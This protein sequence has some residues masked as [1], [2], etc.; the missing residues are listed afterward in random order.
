MKRS[1]WGEP[2]MWSDR[3][4]MG[5]GKKRMEFRGG[6][7]RRGGG[8]HPQKSPMNRNL[9][10]AMVLTQLDERNNPGTRLNQ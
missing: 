10:L 1:G 3:G 5:L 4:G 9:V 6:R 7:G 8:Y 2:R